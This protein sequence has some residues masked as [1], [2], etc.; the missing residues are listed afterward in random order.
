MEIQVRPLSGHPLVEQYLAQDARVLEFFSGSPFD[1]EAYFDR[2]TEVAARFTK[3]QRLAMAEAVRPLS[4]EA[5]AR[6]DAIRSGNGFFVT[7][8]QQPGLFGGPLYTVHKALSAVALAANLER[9]L[10]APVLALFWVASDDHDW[11]E[12]NHAH[13]LD[14][15]NTLRRL[16]LE[17]EAAPPRSMGR[18]PLDDTVESALD[19]LAQALPPSDFVPVLLERLQRAYSPG[20]TVAAAFT[21]TLAALLD[22]LSVG[23]V[24]G[25]SPVIRRL[26][27]PVVREEVA[28]PEA[29]EAALRGTTDALE[30][31]GYG[32]QVPILP[33]ASNVFHEDEEGGRERLVRSGGGWTL[34]SSGRTLSAGDVERYLEEEPERFSANV[35]LRP[36]VESA[37]FPTLAYVAGPGEIR[38]L[39]QTGGL[40]ER[41]GVP[42]PLVY[43]RWSV[44]L[45]ESK[46]AKVL[47]KFGLE[48]DAFRRPVHEVIAERVRDDVPE[49]VT[50]E[51]ARLRARIGE[52]YEA[53]LEAARE[54]DPTLKGPINGARNEAFRG[55]GEVEK[56][57]R[58]HVKLAGEVELDQIEKAAVNL[59]PLGKPQERVLNVHQYLARY[60]AELIPSILE[61]IAA[62]THVTAPP[63]ATL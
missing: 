13:V 57:I 4:G 55:L 39:A 3:E 9:V 48:T 56:K 58:H 61:G 19:E 14:T 27:L 36:V 24:D 21:E 41:H 35:V 47:A 33:G 44:T 43:P 54:V 20:E 45:V 23:L 28:D 50:E 40:F 30:A 37:V 46:V 51:L 1:P 5:S 26:A 22:G 59:A 38:Y 10:E 29:S 52:G 32:T 15:G 62:E 7:T 18:R 11:A 60:G 12:A 49:T 53:L 16:A 6:L 31:A 8:G 2:A 42:M 25:Q 34:R 17:G 63:R